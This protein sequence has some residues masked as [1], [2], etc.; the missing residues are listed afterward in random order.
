MRNQPRLRSGSESGDEPMYL[1]VINTIDQGWGTTQIFIPYNVNRINIT[2]NSIGF[3]QLFNVYVGAVY[4]SGIG[5]AGTWST[6]VTPGYSNTHVTC[7]FK[8]GHSS[9]NT[10]SFSGF[11]N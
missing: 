1:G 9:G 3:L 11:Y 8:S 4:A 5:F 2:C 10:C 6:T 7:G